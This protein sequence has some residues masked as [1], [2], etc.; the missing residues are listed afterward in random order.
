MSTVIEMAIS[1]S[2]WAKDMVSSETKAR[3][4]ATAAMMLSSAWPI[5]KATMPPTPLVLA[6]EHPS[7]TNVTPLEY[8]IRKPNG[9]TVGPRTGVAKS[10]PA[11]TIVSSSNPEM[12]HKLW[13]RVQRLVPKL[14]EINKRLSAVEKQLRKLEGKLK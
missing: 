13:L 9:A 3:K 2:A 5:P 10:V 6:D 4:V 14:P 1:L 12:P 8:K 11:G 7:T